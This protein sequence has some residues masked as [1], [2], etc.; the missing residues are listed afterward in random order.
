MKTLRHQILETSTPSFSTVQ[1]I[2]KIF[3]VILAGT[4]VV[5]LGPAALRTIADA[6]S[7]VLQIFLETCR[8]SL[9]VLNILGR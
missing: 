1:F 4:L 5:A 6:N 2:L 3:F 9:F 8:I 7:L